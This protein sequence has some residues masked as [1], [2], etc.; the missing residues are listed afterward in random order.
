MKALLAI[1]FFIA[2]PLLVAL[3]FRAAKGNS[4]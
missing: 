2:A 1:A 3:F 4:E